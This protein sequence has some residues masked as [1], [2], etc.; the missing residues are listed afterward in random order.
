MSCQS[1]AYR[2]SR[3]LDPGRSAPEALL[4]QWSDQTA[5][6]LLGQHNLVIINHQPT[7]TLQTVC[8]VR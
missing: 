1:S 7:H 8:T 2:R 4:M 6:C 5:F 3:P